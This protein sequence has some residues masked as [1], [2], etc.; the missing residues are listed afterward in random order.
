MPSQPLAWAFIS[1]APRPEL[2]TYQEAMDLLPK[3]SLH[4]VCTRLFQ[5]PDDVLALP[6]RLA[7]G[8][9]THASG[10]RAVV[11]HPTARLATCLC[12]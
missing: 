10:Q 12:S 7:G 9:L 11:I 3:P 8:G 5:L 6:A 4:L 2:G 1:L